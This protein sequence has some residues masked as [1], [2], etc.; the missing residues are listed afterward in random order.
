MNDCS[1]C[2]PSTRLLISQLAG[3]GAALCCSSLPSSQLVPQLFKCSQG[4][5]K[6]RIA[7][8]VEIGWILQ[9]LRRLVVKQAREC[10]VFH[11]F[12]PDIYSSIRDLTLTVLALQFGVEPSEGAL[13]DPNIGQFEVGPLGALIRAE[14]AVLRKRLRSMV[15]R[16]TDPFP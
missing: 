8:R 14:Q 9:L 3:F 6:I 12:C 1:V 15:S 13:V 7:C 16:D 2:R 10:D 11:E 4:G 5:A